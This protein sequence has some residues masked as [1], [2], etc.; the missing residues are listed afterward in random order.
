MASWDDIRAVPML[1]LALAGGL[2]IGLVSAFAQ[3]SSST[4]P[5]GTP[6]IAAP[7]RPEPR[8]MKWV[9]HEQAQPT[10]DSRPRRDTM[11]AGSPPA[12][13]TARTA[14]VYY[15]GCREVR[16]AGAAPLY[17]GQPG[18]RP[19]MDGDSDGIACEAYR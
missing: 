11:A 2:A 19:E 13:R 3:G 12:R 18:Y 10:A 7:G 15:S 4:S 5:A 16:A 1:G 17:A 8:P 14:N 6:Q 9:V